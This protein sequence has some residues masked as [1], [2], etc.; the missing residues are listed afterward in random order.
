M[1][2]DRV[3]G[4]PARAEM[5]CR[6][7]CR[8]RLLPNPVPSVNRRQENWKTFENRPKIHIAIFDRRNYFTLFINSRK[9]GNEVL[10]TPAHYSQ[11]SKIKLW[12]NIF[13]KQVDIHALIN[14]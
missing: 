11:P 12:W 4:A 8:R 5:G 1:K 10:E 6:A 7:G 13:S 14:I 2:N 9:T 3:T